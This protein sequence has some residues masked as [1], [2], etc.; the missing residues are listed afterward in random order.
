[1]SRLRHETA[2]ALLRI[3][4]EGLLHTRHPKQPKATR[5]N[6]SLSLLFFSPLSKQLL[7]HPTTHSSSLHS[8]PP[9]TWNDFLCIALRGTFTTHMAAQNDGLLLR[10]PIVSIKNKSM[11][12]RTSCNARQVGD[13]S[14]QRKFGKSNPPGRAREE[15]KRGK[16]TKP[17]PPLCFLS[18]STP[19]LL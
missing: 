1:M 14:Q 2:A 17:P 19:N 9:P 18:I 12:L 3:L 6:D 5:Q 13:N 4:V 8:I 16:T 15:K 11:G 7:S 10:V